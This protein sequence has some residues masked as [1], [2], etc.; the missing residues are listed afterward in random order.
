M[1][2]DRVI[3]LPGIG[4]HPCLSPAMESVVAAGYRVLVPD[5]PGFDGRS[6]FRP[7]D[8]HLGW[9]TATW[10]AVDAVLGN[11][12][13]PCHVVGASVGGMLAADLAVFRPELVRSLTLIDPFG[14]FD[15]SC[16]GFDLYAVVS[17]ERAGHLFAKGVPEVF[18]T[19]FAERGDDEAPVARYL[20]EIAMASLLWPLGDR[21]LA[22][23][24]HRL[25]APRLTLWGELD[26]VLPVALA[27]RWSDDPTVVVGAGHLAEWDAPE[28]VAAAV[29]SFLSGSAGA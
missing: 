21:R 26:E 12:S 29:L 17:S 27:P 11:D 14:I 7:P 5:L 6:G 3:Y 23:R 15:E 13:S 28:E 10:D 18:P 25:H 2:N 4:G 8:D 22:D 9:L 24:I 19:R 1:P 20:T 16:P